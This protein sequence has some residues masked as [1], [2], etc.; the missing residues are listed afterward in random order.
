M[1]QQRVADLS[2]EL[3]ALTQALVQMAARVAGIGSELAGLTGHLLRECPRCGFRG[4][5]QAFSADTCLPCAH[6]IRA[7]AEELEKESH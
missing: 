4:P 6:A 1:N 3:Q 5:H 2:K 7:E